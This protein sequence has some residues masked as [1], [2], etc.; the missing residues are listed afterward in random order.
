M[1]LHGNPANVWLWRRRQQS[2]GLV[3][4]RLAERSHEFQV[5]QV[6]ACDGVSADPI[7]SWIRRFG[8]KALLIEPQPEAFAR[9]QQAYEGVAGIEMTNVAVAAEPG[10]LTLFRPKVT[11]GDDTSSLL[12]ASFRPNPTLASRGQ[13]E[14]VV[15]EAVTFDQVLKRSEIDRVDMLQIDVEG[16]DGE[17][18]RLFDFGRYMPSIVHYEHRHLSYGERRQCRLMLQELG[19]ELI[20]MRHDTGGFLLK[21]TRVDSSSVV[22]A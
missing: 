11:S 12:T 5:I 7:H 16:M 14:E 19:Y 17:L 18:L 9:L 13:I 4:E 6:G 1:W 21:S 22:V 10:R 3:V 8:W 2:F 15:V 20:V